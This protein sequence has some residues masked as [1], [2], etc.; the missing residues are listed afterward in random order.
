MFKKVITDPCIKAD[1]ES[2]QVEGYA[3]VSEVVDRAGDIVKKGA[4]T[5]T[6][7]ERGS[8]PVLW[9]HDTNTPIGRTRILK[10]DD[11]GLFFKA[12][13]VKGIKK[14]DEAMLL[15]NAGVIN[16]MSIGFTL[17][18]YE[19]IGDA[20][21][22]LSISEIDLSEISIV[23]LPANEYTN[24]NL[25]DLLYNEDLNNLIHTIKT[26]VLDVIKKRLS[27]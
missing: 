24:V 17:K 21:K 18:E 25:K 11:K 3:S 15:M 8:V 6:I 9:Q 2:Y 13:L 4:F 12:N 23:T 22:G 16:A 14:A 20:K 5:K 1:L 27:C 7:K 26:E 10:E 19:V